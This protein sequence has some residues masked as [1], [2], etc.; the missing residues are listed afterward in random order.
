MSFYRADKSHSRE[1]GRIGLG[2]S[3]VKAIM[4]AHNMNYGYN[5]VTDAVEFWFEV[6]KANEEE[7]GGFDE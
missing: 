4:D 3:I 7:A 5:N 1:E 6:K 2:L